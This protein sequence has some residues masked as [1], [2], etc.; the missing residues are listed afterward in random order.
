MATDLRRLARAAVAAVA[1][2]P[3]AVIAVLYVGVRTGAFLGVEPTTYLDTL[4]YNRASGQPLISKAFLA[5]ERAWTVPLFYKV[6]TG[7]DARIWMQLVLSIGCWLTLAAAVAQTLRVRYL[8][9]IGFAT[10]LGFS[11]SEQVLRWDALLL[12]ESI[13]TSLMVLTL[14]AWLFVL[15]RPTR[16]RATLLAAALVLWVFS[17]DPHA[18]L[19]LMA[20]PALLVWVA[21]PGRR[22]PRVAI[23]VGVCALA[24]AG[25][26]SLSEGNRWQLPLENVIALR[27]AP[28]PEALA[29]F[30][31]HGMPVDRRFLL[32]AEQY[33]LTSH[34]PF[35]FPSSVQPL[36]MPWQRWFQ[37]H[38]RS[39]YAHYLASHPHELVRPLHHTRDFLLDPLLDRY[40]ASGSPWPLPPLADSLY[41]RGSIR[42]L[43]YVAI[44]LLL[45]LVAGLRAGVR[46]EWVVP[47]FVLAAALPC[48]MLIWLG[49][50]KEVA[51]HGL[52]ASQLLRLGTL[53]L[54]L[55]AL[56]ALLGRPR[57]T[58]TS[59]RA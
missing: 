37:R 45:A 26:W 21:L 57:R 10:V 54:V 28:N 12:S 58:P 34:N 59:S 35:P 49:D 9:V 48:G 39:T 20:V 8:R 5:G 43:V 16:P 42:P 50:S 19:L 32:L 27:I 22:R 7:Q 15:Q 25:L 18:Y 40:R 11:L 14:A 13:A 23:V 33:R 46:R 38:G 52:L 29:Y 51:R 36:L 1:A 41:P 30:H 24:V 56:D 4:G 53:L 31:D 47:L 2:H 17:R 44:A 3:L 55:F 6:F